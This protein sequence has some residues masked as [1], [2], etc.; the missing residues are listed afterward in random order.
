VERRSRPR[1]RQRATRRREADAAWKGILHAL[2]PEFVAFAHPDLHEAID[3]SRRPEFLDKE[4]QAIARRAATGRRYVDLLVKVWQRDGQEQWLLIHVEVQSQAEEQFAER[5]YLY[6]ALLFLQHRR[7]VVSLAVL[8]DQR[9]EWRPAT[10]AYDHWGCAL[11]FRYPVVKLLD[12]RGREDELAGSENLFAQAALAQLAALTS[13]GQ[14]EPLA[15]ARR[16]VLRRLLRAGYAPAQ[17]AA[18]VTFMDMTLGLPDDLAAR[19]DAEIASAEGITVVQFMSRYE[20]RGW[21]RGLAEGRAQGQQEL[22][23]QQ[24]AGRWGEPD[25]ALQERVRSLT[26]EQVLALGKALFDFTA[27]TD[28]EAWLTTYAPRSE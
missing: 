7:P 23:L 16:L 15:A 9:A 5:M 3:W 12:W 22:L 6:H 19:I 24:I 11:Q 10:F 1:P 14:L 18:L 25:Q 28:L 2:L 26:G 27:R 17:V 13:R 21:E 8:I 20:L 4:V